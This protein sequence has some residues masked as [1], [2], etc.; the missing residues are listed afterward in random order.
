MVPEGWKEQPLGIAAKV[1]DCKHRTPVYADEGYP[2]ISPG[3]IRWGEVD[4]KSCR[5]I[6]VHELES[7]MDHCAVRTGDIVMGRNQ[8]VGI[9]AYVADDTKF[10]LGQDTILIQ[11]TAI[12]PRYL[13]DF[14][15]SESFQSQIYRLLGGSTFARINLGD[16]RRLTVLVPPLPEQKKIAEILSTWDK[17]IETTEALLANARTQKRALMQSLL[18]GTRRFPGF[19]DHPWREVRLGDT[20]LERSERGRKGLPLL[21]IT[22]GRGVVGQ[23]ET[24]RR[25]TSREDKSSYKRICV[26]DIGYNTM[27]MWQGV[28]ALSGREGLVSPAYTIVRPGPRI[29]GRFAAHLFKHPEV[30]DKFRR[31]SQG[32]TSDTWNLKF[33][34]FAKIAVSMPV[35]EEQGRIVEALD[36]ADS[37]VRDL[38]TQADHLRT[39][40]KSL[41]QQL[42]TGKR[43]VAV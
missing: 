23:D 17:A 21:S 36:F 10:A 19:E 37:E 26:G 5:R 3:N 12:N 40:K 24:D 42:L 2:I 13:Y 16:I 15:A 9:G 22:S 43:R 31:H 8:S 33:P 34:K 41:M 4:L 1:V 39:E 11:P 27:R 32:L 35:I 20:F 6:E 28:S 30:I 29:M 14:T 38:K 7:M 18:T 25:D